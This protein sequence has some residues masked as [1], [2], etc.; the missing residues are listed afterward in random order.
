MMTFYISDMYTKFSTA[1]TPYFPL[2]NKSF[3]SIFE[4]NRKTIRITTPGSYFCDTYTAITITSH[5]TID[6]ATKESLLDINQK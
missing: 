2:P 4:D 5:S 3:C 1:A 6:E